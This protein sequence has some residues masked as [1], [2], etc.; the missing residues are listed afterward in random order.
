M[1]SVVEGVY[2][3]LMPITFLI[4]I[5]M[6]HLWYLCIKH[7][8]ITTLSAI[9]EKDKYDDRSIYWLKIK[10]AVVMLLLPRACEIYCNCS[11]ANVT[12]KDGTV[13]NDSND[14]NSK[15]T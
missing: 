5:R 1:T 9:E 7:N 4:V 3:V 2:Y 14:N 11:A 13:V 6:L 15:T 12:T 10:N 8:I